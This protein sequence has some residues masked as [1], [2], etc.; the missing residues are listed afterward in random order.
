MFFTAKACAAASKLAMA[1]SANTIAYPRS[2]ASRAVD[3]TPMLVE[4]PH[5]TRV[6][7][8]RRLSWRSNSVP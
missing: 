8:P 4:M 6:V 2:H 1:S 7:I 5:I 3:S